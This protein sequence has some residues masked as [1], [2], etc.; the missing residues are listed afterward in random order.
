MACPITL[1]GRKWSTVEILFFIESWIELTPFGSA[2]R[3]KM[4]QYTVLN[5]MRRS[6]NAANMAAD[7]V[8]AIQRAGRGAAIQ[9][10]DESFTQGDC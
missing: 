10:G 6:L 2:N 3:V 8:S 1:R 7:V 5:A 4:K 9:N